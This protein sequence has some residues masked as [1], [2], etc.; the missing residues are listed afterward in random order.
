MG[1]NFY[2]M[3][4]DKELV[5][6]NFA[7]RT[8][9][10]V[11]DEEYEIVDDPYLGYKIHLNKLSCGWRPLFQRHKE[12]KK[13]KDLEQFYHKYRDNIEIFDEYN[14][15]YTWEEYFKR[16]YRHSLR[17][18]EPE[19]WVYEIDPIFHDTKKTLHTVKCSEKEA[20]VFIPFDHALYAKTE[21]EAMRRL[22]VYQPYHY[23]QK[24]WN[25]PDYLFDWTEGE[26]S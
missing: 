24:Y 12:F 14:E 5:Q 6:N 15:K 22:K 19:K 20:D 23:E 25:D 18:R 7:M 10:Y 3:M 9:W 13:F 16:V 8:E 4:R 26:F 21:R 17:E 11:Y 1:T 2:F